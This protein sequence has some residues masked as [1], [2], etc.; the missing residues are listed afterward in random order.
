MWLTGLRV[1]EASG[2]RTEDVRSTYRQLLICTSKD[3]RDRCVPW[4]PNLDAELANWLTIRDRLTEQLLGNGHHDPGYLWPQLHTVDQGTRSTRAGDRL[5]DRTIQ[6]MVK[7]CALRA[8]L[9]DWITPHTL[10]HSYATHMLEL[11]ITLPELQL[12]LGHADIATTT[13]YLHVNPIRLT[14]RVRALPG[15]AP[16]PPGTPP[17]T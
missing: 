13:I 5:S 14:E 11:G 9:P 16:C 7:R 6:R 3:G 2:L 15:G 12:L 8:G 17:P 1:S 10:R 4:P